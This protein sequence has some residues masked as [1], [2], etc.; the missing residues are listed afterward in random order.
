VIAASASKYWKGAAAASASL[1]AAYVMFMSPWSQ[2]LGR[3]EW[4]VK[5][6]EKVVALTFDD[7][8]N[9]P[10]TGQIIDVLEAHDAVGTF[11]IVGRNIDRSPDVVRRVADSRHELG[12][13]SYRH[14]IR[15][16]FAGDRT[17]LHEIEATQ[18]RIED[19]A[20]VRPLLFRPPWLY[21]TPRMLRAVEASGMRTIGGEFCHVFE[22]LQPDATRIAKA[23]LRKIKPGSIVIF[24]DGFNARQGVNR[25][26]TVRAVDLVVT[27][28]AANNWQMVSVSE[29]LQVTERR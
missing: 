24:H 4:R 21:R 8:P 23:A 3:F 19:F 6:T 20:A 17:F 12:N 5:T 14:Q 9:E 7:G 10:F 26:E 22:V 27:A 13:H 11:F 18:R 16:F 25:A 28:L 1:S 29:L 15:Q 2:L